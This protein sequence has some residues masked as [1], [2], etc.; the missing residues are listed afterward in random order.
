MAMK[1]WITKY[2]LSDG[3]FTVAGDGPSSDAP[4]MISYRHNGL[5]QY[6]HRNDWWRNEADALARAERMRLAKIESHKSSIKK[7]EQMSFIRIKEVNDATSA[8]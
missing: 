2:A 1:F 5:T 4:G 7:L 3:I 8:K 6:A